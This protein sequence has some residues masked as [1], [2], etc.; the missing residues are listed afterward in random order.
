MLSI[1]CW[2]ELLLDLFSPQRD[3]DN[4]P[5]SDWSKASE[6]LL[7]VVH[8]QEHP[9][10]KSVSE[11]AGNG[12]KVGMRLLCGGIFGLFLRSLQSLGFLTNPRQ[13]F[14]LGLAVKV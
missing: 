9:V 13:Q 14:L 6:D 12:R 11:E 5:L 10:H 1:P 8:K 3:P 2:L 7:S 4:L